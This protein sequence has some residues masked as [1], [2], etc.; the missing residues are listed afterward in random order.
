MG[1]TDDKDKKYFSENIIRFKK[2]SLSATLVIILKN[3]D[4]LVIL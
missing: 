3:L 2:I 1:K 4:L